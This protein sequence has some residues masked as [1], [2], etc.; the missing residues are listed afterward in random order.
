MAGNGS[1]VAP[2]A[3]VIRSDDEEQREPLYPDTVNIAINPTRE[4]RV[5]RRSQRG[6][7][8][9]SIAGSIKYREEM[10]NRNDK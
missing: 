6:I 1:H 4:R 9:A 7:D 5:E 3:T 2:E 8:M 10:R